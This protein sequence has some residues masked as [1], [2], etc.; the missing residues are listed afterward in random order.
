MLADSKIP[1]YFLTE[2]EFMV[3]NVFYRELFCPLSYQLG[4]ECN[5]SALLIILFVAQVSFPLCNQFFTH[6]SP[7]YITKISSSIPA[8]S[9]CKGG[10]GCRRHERKRAIG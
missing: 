2:S 7:L 1:G 5:I 6:A 4:N 8:P 10:S 9:A 3:E